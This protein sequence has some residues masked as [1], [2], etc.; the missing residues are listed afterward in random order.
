MKED[1]I[2]FD[3]Q[4]PDEKV[5]LLRRRHPWVMLKTGFIILIIVLLVLVGFLIWGAS[6]YS[7]VIL[8]AGLVVSLTIFSSQWFV[9]ANDIY[10]LTNER[11]INV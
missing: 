2:E 6:I 7:V 1:E 5:I 11:I 8:I 4:R 3:N 10:I 9:Y